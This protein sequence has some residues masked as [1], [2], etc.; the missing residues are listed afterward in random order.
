MAPGCW[1]STRRSLQ[2]TLLLLLWRSARRQRQPAWEER[3]REKERGRKQNENSIVDCRLLKTIFYFSVALSLSRELP[4]LAQ[5]LLLVQRKD[6][7]EASHIPSLPNQYDNSS[8][9]ADAGVGPAPRRR[10]NSDDDGELANALDL[11]RASNF[12]HLLSFT[13]FLQQLDQPR[14]QVSSTTT[15][16]G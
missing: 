10:N 8:R 9:G 15:R 2:T 1:L 4:T 14:R 16:F 13:P 3:R 5:K 6:K 11:D 7:G 12:F